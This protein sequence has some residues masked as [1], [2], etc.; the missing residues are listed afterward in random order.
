MNLQSVFTNILRKLIGW[1]LIVV[2]TFFF[3]ATI[4]LLTRGDYGPSLI[5]LFFSL[6]TFGL[7]LSIQ[8]NLVKQRERM[9]AIFEMYFPRC[10][11]CKSNKG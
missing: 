3:A 8:E 2:S 10:P 5:G 9:L 7:G 4:I 11:I 6:L 1:G